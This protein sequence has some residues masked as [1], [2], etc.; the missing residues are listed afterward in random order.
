MGIS[1]GQYLRA[2]EELKK[3]VTAAVESISEG[4]LVVLL[5]N[6]SQ[7]QLVSDAHGLQTEYVFA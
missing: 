5:V 3:E 7:Q 2:V 6:F 4:A 1:E